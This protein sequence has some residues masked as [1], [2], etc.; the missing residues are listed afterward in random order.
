MERLIVV[1]ERIFTIEEFFSP[2]ECAHFIEL[3]ER[4]GY[5]D[6][7]VTTTTGPQMR[8]DIRN[9]ARVLLDDPALALNLWERIAPFVPSPLWK[10][11]AIGLNE[12]LRFYRYDPGQTF[13]PHY[14]GSFKRDNGERSQVTFMVYL[15]GDFTGGAT[16]F[17]LPYPYHEVSVQP[18]AGMALLFWHSL[19]HEGAPVWSGRKYVLRSDV[20]YSAL[21]PG[22]TED[23]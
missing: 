11:T 18:K 13:K 15:N 8:S 10:R 16:K 6:A 12:R 1:P 3:S 22:E 19:R 20:M 7:P 4:V 5:G 2:D 21:P 17:D 9:N 23:I 14:D